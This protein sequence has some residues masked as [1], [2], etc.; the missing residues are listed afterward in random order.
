MSDKEKGLFQKYIVER[1]DGRELKGGMA[2]VLEVGDPNTWP[3]LL[4][5]ADTVAEEGYKALAI[6]I[7]KEVNGRKIVKQTE[8]KRNDKY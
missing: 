6:D 2:F 1:V 3:A 8:K 7:R 5:Y 4:T